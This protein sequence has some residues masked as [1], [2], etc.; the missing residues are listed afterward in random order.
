MLKLIDLRGHQIAHLFHSG[1]RGFPPKQF[2]VLTHDACQDCAAGS[3]SPAGSCRLSRTADLIRPNR[4]NLRSAEPHRAPR[5]FSVFFDKT[6]KS[7]RAQPGAIIPDVSNPSPAATEDRSKCYVSACF[8]FICANNLLIC[9]TDY[10]VGAA[11][12]QQIPQL[13]Q[14]LLKKCLL[15]RK[16]AR[17]KSGRLSIRNGSLAGLMN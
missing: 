8:S 1:V 5:S 13:H 17:I 16:T 9:L 4:G 12:P 15:E 6:P 2:C 3:I 7:P 11:L 10:C 14:K